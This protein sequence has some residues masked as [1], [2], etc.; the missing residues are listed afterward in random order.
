MY[1]YNPGRVK[2]EKKTFSSRRYFYPPHL[3]SF[4][5]F[6]LKKIGLDLVMV[7]I[8]VDAMGF[9]SRLCCYLFQTLNPFL[10]Y[11]MILL[12]LIRRIVNLIAHICH[13]PII[14]ILFL[15]LFTVLLRLLHYILFTCD[16]WF[17]IM[18]SS[19]KSFFFLLFA[20]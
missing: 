2:L 5:I 6:V 20:L 7:V 10:Y 17:F 12:N 18:P 15:A 4:V 14:I 1:R 8:G 11:L 3:F 9:L 19:F 16:V 13:Y